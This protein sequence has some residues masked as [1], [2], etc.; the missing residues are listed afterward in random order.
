MLSSTNVI[1]P[2]EVATFKSDENECQTLGMIILL[3]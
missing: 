3:F 1:K 2:D